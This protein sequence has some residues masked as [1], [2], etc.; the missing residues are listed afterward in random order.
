MASLVFAWLSAAAFAASLAYFLYSY[1]VRFGA[2]ADGTGSSGILVPVA[3]NVLLFSVFALHHSVFARTGIKTAVARR[4]SPAFERSLYTLVASVLFWL[5][6]WFWRP[7]P[8]TAWILPGAWAWAG[9]A[10]V[11]AGLAITTAGARTLGV[12]DLAGVSRRTPTLRTD[13]VYGIVR[14][15]LYFG[16]FLLVFGVPGMSLTRFT[17]AVV[18][19]LYLAV[20]IPFEERNL[21]ETFGP[22]YA[23]YRRKVRWRMLPGIY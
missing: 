3:V 7:V 14:H 12:L 9:Y 1:F 4:V 19:T 13:S 22:D 17:F 10:M 23:S 18:S 5:V 11:A 16:W 2:P 6:C 8:G 21:V 20:A 15:P